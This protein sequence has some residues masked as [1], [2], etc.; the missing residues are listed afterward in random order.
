MMHDPVKLI[1]TYTPLLAS[2]LLPAAAVVAAPTLKAMFAEGG[3]GLEWAGEDYVLE[4]SQNLVSNDWSAVLDETMLGTDPMNVQVPPNADRAFYRLTARGIRDLLADNPEA[5]IESGNWRSGDGVS[6]Y[7]GT[8]YL[9]SGGPG[10]AMRWTPPVLLAS[11]YDIYV[12]HTAHTNRTAKALYTIGH[13]EGQDA[14]EV[15]Q[16]KDGGMWHH[17]GRY[18][19]GADG[20]DYIRLTVGADGRSTVGDAVRF[21]QHPC[22]AGAVADN[23]DAVTGGIWKSGRS[24]GGYVGEDYLFISAGAGGGFASWNLRVPD[25]GWYDFYVTYTDSSNRSTGT[26]YQIDHA[27]GQAFVT[28]DQ[29]VDAESFGF[30]RYTYLGTYPASATNDVKVTVFQQSD[31]I[32]SAD[33][34]FLRCHDGGPPVAGDWELIFYD[35]F[36]GTELDESKWEAMDKQVYQSTKYRST[37]WKENVELTNGVLRLVTKKENRSGELDDGDFHEWQEYT[38]GGIKSGDPIAKYGYFEARMKYAPTNGLNNAFWSTTSKYDHPDTEI[39]RQDITME[40]GTQLLRGNERIHLAN[41]YVEDNGYSNIRGE[42]YFSFQDLGADFHIFGFEWNETNINWY[43]DGML[44]ESYTNEDCHF[45]NR[46]Y[47]STMLLDGAGLAVDH[48][49]ALAGEAMEVDWVR[50]YQLRE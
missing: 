12:S 9:Y 10:A 35:E 37:R 30:R 45:S 49:D 2:L 41:Q 8:N 40:G 16:T 14:V 47:F 7:W 33:A 1:R 24:A 34:V 5:V 43:L 27:E 3:L 6:G 25:S 17:L 19:I 23:D 22:N 39:K 15:D 4:R 26:V 32:V 28:L 38:T 11:R 29:T 46:V 44:L 48:A 18:F 42:T 31:G 36:S 50:V 13:R 21:I 20:D